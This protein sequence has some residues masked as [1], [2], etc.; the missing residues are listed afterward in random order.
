[1]LT[2]EVWTMAEET[3]GEESIL[4]K[5]KLWVSWVDC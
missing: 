4:Y 2:W 5:G 1:M 3:E